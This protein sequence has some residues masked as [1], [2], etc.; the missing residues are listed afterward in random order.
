FGGLLGAVVGWLLG[1]QVTTGQFPVPTVGPVV[2]QWVLPSTLVGLL[3]GAAIG[4]LVGALA[5]IT[6][7]GRPPVTSEVV[8]PASTGD[9]NVVEADE[10]R[11]APFSPASEESATLAQDQEP[12]VGVTA[13]TLEEEIP[14]GAHERSELP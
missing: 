3:A 14:A 4:A 10:L 12:L 7:V 13:S 2:G 1:A 11:A 6:T 9:A 5:A 8:T